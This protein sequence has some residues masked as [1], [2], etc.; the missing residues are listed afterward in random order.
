VRVTFEGV[1]IFIV[2]SFM[3]VFG[4]LFVS[5]ISSNINDVV[6]GYDNDTIPVESKELSAKY[7]DSWQFFDKGFGVLVLGSLVAIVVA[8]RKFPESSGWFLLG[9]LVMAVVFGFLGFVLENLYFEVA[10]ASNLSAVSS[11]WVVIPFFMNHY[12][13]VLVAY[14]LIS[15]FA[16]LTSDGGLSF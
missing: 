16:A 13:L 3:F 9:S 10:N 15:S 2:A 11:G 12:I 5:T 1:S 8:V 6:Q 7:N 4:L 14:V